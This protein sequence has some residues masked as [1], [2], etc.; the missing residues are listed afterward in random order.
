MRRGSLG[1]II[2]PLE[3]QP[4]PAQQTAPVVLLTSAARQAYE[5]MSTLLREDT[6]EFSSP[7]V[8][9]QFAL[10]AG[11][12]GLVP[13]QCFLFFH[14]V[15]LQPLL[16][17]MDLLANCWSSN[18][19]AWWQW[20]LLPTLFHALVIPAVLG[21][22]MLVAGW[23]SAWWMNHAELTVATYSF[24]VQTLTLLHLAACDDR[25]DALLHE[26]LLA[27]LLPFVCVTAFHLSWRRSSAVGTIALAVHIVV[28]PLMLGG[29]SNAWLARTGALI[30]SNLLLFF[31]GLYTEAARR[32]H[33][34]H[35]LGLQR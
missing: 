4:A 5:R 24:V 15:L 18:A 7:T 27:C 13:F 17:L 35:N 23:A 21:G 6:S 25:S 11:R 20:L 8:E 14:L 34:R 9:A 1:A 16:L 22:F 19:T 2:T 32:T 33:F 10:A 12:A 31:T 28:G 29:T 26:L 3:A 30:L